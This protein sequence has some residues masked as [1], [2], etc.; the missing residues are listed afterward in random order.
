[1]GTLIFNKWSVIVQSKFD[2][3][4]FIY[5][6]EFIDIWSVLWIKLDW[7]FWMIKIELFTKHLYCLTNAVHAISSKPICVQGVNVTCSFL[8]QLGEWG[9][10]KCLQKDKSSILTMPQG[11]AQI[12]LLL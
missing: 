6:V 2:I 10:L 9:I 8:D 5:N 1:M 12:S 3:S 11:G 4:L 7:T